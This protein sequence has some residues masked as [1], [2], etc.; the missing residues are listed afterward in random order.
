MK[1]TFKIIYYLVLAA[2][3]FFALLLM[4]SLFPIA[5][6]IKILSVLSG[7][8]EPALHTGSVIIIKPTS[9][10]QVGDVI[11]FGKNT[12]TEV[13]TT[14]RIAE[15]K[16]VSGEAVFKTKGDA[17]HSEDSKEVLQNEVLGKV[18]FSIPLFGY[19]VDFVRKP[20]GLMLVIVI[21]AIVIIYDEINKI[22]KEIKIIKKGKTLE[23]KDENDKE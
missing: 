12:K 3:I 7:S 11:T 13:P 21:P 10:Y 2:V 19:L 14:H 22:I 1:K 17:N 5:G 15:I 6:N 20:L 9:N 4:V 8:M 23:K 16:V 18:Y